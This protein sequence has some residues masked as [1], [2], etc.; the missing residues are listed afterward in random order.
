MQLCNYEDLKTEIFPKLQINPFIEV[1]LKY[2]ISNAFGLINNK[3]TQKKPLLSPDIIMRVGHKPS[4]PLWLPS[5]N[6][7]VLTQHRKSAMPSW[8]IA[9]RTEDEDDEEGED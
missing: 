6:T 5:M 3:Q 2:M 8:R 7:T 1:S 4:C 9:S